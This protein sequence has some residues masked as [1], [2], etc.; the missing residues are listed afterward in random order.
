VE[1]SAC[2]CVCVWGGVFVIFSCAGLPRSLRACIQVEW[3]ANK[4]T[5]LQ[6][7]LIA[8]V[9]LKSQCVA[10]AL[11]R[12][13]WVKQAAIGEDGLCAPRELC[14]LVP[15]VR[16]FVKHLSWRSEVG[17]T[18]GQRS[19]GQRATTVGRDGE[20]HSFFG[21]DHAVDK[22]SAAR[23]DRI[24][25]V[26]VSWVHCWRDVGG[27]KLARLWPHGWQDGVHG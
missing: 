12:P 3:L 5:V 20:G 2:V 11:A 10:S 9:E 15:T 17:H 19:E 14:V 23:W 26:A 21:G 4:S 7:R 27:R 13:L 18:V 16:S 6:V 8:V 22:R 24:M 1:T 25:L